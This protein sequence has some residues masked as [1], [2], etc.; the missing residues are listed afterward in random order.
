M[1]MY[2]AAKDV[3]AERLRQIEQEGWSN[4]HDDEH[5]KGD[6]AVAAA[7]YA[8]FAVAE[9]DRAD[10]A[11]LTGFVK[12]CWPWASEWWKPNIGNPRRDLVKA[13]ALILAEIERLDRAKGNEENTQSREPAIGAT[14]YTDVGGWV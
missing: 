11:K 9:D 3:F 14:G 2:R 4:E 8:A 1:E 12:S 5:N 7:C 10:A 13:A 6:L